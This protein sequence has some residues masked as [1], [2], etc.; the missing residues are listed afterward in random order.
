MWLDPRLPITRVNS[1]VFSIFSACIILK[2]EV[3]TFWFLCEYLLVLI[4]YLNNL[5][6]WV[7]WKKERYVFRTSTSQSLARVERKVTY[8]HFLFSATIFSYF[9]LQRALYACHHRHAP[10]LASREYVDISAEKGIRS[11][12]HLWSS[13]RYNKLQ[14]YLH[15]RRIRMIQSCHEMIG[16][17]VC[18]ASHGST[19]LYYLLVFNSIF[20]FPP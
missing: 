1:R 14:Q 8:W 18:G 5:R 20:H 9:R 2:N 3:N 12:T 6:M 4:S 16:I 15:Y 19:Q 7:C 10:G 17:H 13:N 11:W